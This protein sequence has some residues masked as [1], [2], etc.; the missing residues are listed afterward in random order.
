MNCK[1]FKQMSQTFAAYDL[2]GEVKDWDIEVILRF[3]LF[4]GLSLS[5]D[6][7]AC[8]G[9]GVEVVGTC[10]YLQTVQRD[11]NPV[12]FYVEND[13][14]KWHNDNTV[15][16]N[17]LGSF[18]WESTYKKIGESENIYDGYSLKRQK[19]TPY[20]VLK[21]GSLS[22]GEC[23]YQWGSNYWSSVLDQRAR[24]GLCSRG[25]ANNG[26]CSPRDL[27]ANTVASNS[28]RSY[29]GSAQVL[30]KRS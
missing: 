27:A 16:K 10:K 4:D 7:F 19:E 13:Q 29:G 8:W 1:G 12:E 18:D 25:A 26:Y 23:F 3:S 21:G 11:G 5:G 20:S 17:D 22:T 28:N 2:A 15:S 9:G 6:I 24:I 14:R 30:L